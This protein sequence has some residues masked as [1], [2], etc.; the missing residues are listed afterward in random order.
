AALVPS[1]IDEFPALFIAAANADGTTRLGQA[2]ELRH[3]ESDRIDAMASGLQELGVVATP[4]DD[5]IEIVGRPGA[6]GGGAIDSRGDHR[7]AMAFAVAGM[8][9]RAPIALTGCAA[10]AT[11]FPG[12]VET[13][14]RAGM[15]ISVAK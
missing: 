9:A 1:A 4:L 7:I 3:K 11:S 12:F 15:N 14:R 10:I 13:A 8:L 2:D 5:G 6:L